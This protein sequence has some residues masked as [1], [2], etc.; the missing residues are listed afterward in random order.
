M[1]MR[2]S[3]G[4][5]LGAAALVLL[6]TPAAADSDPLVVEIVGGG[7]L[8]EITGMYPGI[9]VESAL[10]SVSNSTD[11]AGSVA[12]RVRDVVSDD[13][14]CN[15]PE[16]VVD[17]TCGA[18]EGELA[19]QVVLTVER[20]TGD[21]TW[22]TVASEQPLAELAAGVPLEDS[23]PAGDTHVYRLILHLPPGSGN[24]TQT[25]SIDFDVAIVGEAV[26]DAQV[27]GATA[28]GV[29]ATTGLALPATGAT[30]SAPLLAAMA[31]LV[32]GAGLVALARRSDRTSR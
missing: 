13:N 24:E 11:E 6:G 30:L 14:G 32:T 19:D 17:S 22:E 31:C 8:L 23:L 15:A 7:P 10:L 27:L 26:V 4:A 3:L 5:C 2:R 20:R 28:L 9:E 12:L 18:E 21:D 16:S 29:R 25:D 1:S